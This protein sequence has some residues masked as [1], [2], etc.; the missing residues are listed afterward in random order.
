M[1]RRCSIESF[2]PAILLNDSFDDFNT[3]G[4]IN[5]INW[6]FLILLLGICFWRVAHETAVGS[7]RRAGKKVKS[8]E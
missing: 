2:V 3:I 6:C 4:L 1:K 7:T 8:A 5:Q